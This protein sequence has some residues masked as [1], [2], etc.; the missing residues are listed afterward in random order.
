MKVTRLRILVA[1]LIGLAAAWAILVGIERLHREPENYT[2]IEDGLWMGGNTELPPPGTRAVLNL[3]EFEDPYECEVHAWVKVRDA[4]APSIAWLQE[5]VEF[6]ETQRGAGRTTFVHCFQG[7][8]RSGLVVT[9]YLMRKHSWT[10][11]EAIAKIREKRPQLR[12]NPAFMELLSEWENRPRRLACTGPACAGE[13]PALRPLQIP[14]LAIGTSNQRLRI[15]IGDE[16]FLR[17]PLDAA[18]ESIRDVAEM[19][20]FCQPA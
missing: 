5:Q 19:I 18:A 6:I 15:R 20:G 4:K 11:D 14:P 13:P 8:S 1:L 2:L 16:Q 10:R 7:V 9:A 17:V 12:P 3:C